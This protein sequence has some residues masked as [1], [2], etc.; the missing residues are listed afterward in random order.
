[1]DYLK[2][3]QFV[4]RLKKLYDHISAGGGI[5][6]FSC[7]RD[8]LDLMAETMNIRKIPFL[9]ISDTEGN[10][11]FLIQKDD[12]N[13]VMDVTNYV[14]SEKAQTCT[15]TS[16]DELM[17]KVL[18][19][20]SNHKGLISLTGLSAAQLYILE[21]MAVRRLGVSAIGED[22]MQDGTYRFSVHGKSAIKKDKAQVNLGLLLL[23]M[24]MM[25]EGPGKDKNNWRA[26]NGFY[27]SSNIAGILKGERT[28]P[29]YLVEGRQ[30]MKISPG[31]FECGY[32]KYQNGQFIMTPSLVYQKEIPDY[33]AQLIS[34][35]GRFAEPLCTMDI[36]EAYQSMMNVS[37]YDLTEKERDVIAS[38]KLVA[39]TVNEKVLQKVFRD[40]T[41]QLGGQY[42][43]KAAHVIGEMG[44]VMKGAINGITPPG[45]DEID[46]KS[47]NT[48][49]RTEGL[50]PEDYYGVAYSMDKL[51]I[52][53]IA[54][55]VE[56][57]DV[58]RRLAELSGDEFIYR[59]EELVI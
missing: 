46:V 17:K 15:I 43:S 6:V 14:L 7:R 28:N 49:M 54:E 39:G 12:K 10:N 20:N 19:S 44:K 4:V 38:E 55:K 58:D 45:Y 35:L 50:N 16:T 41:M 47:I 29:F 40:P 24:Q 1:M 52:V 8:A 31:E 5:S 51:E 30:Y 21:Q 48:L 22:L 11:G 36:S 57:I 25:T 27:Y 23:E 32:G 13:A 42:A 3:H 9:I 26:G 37:R 18:K 53:P 59:D 2:Q 33:E 34:N 56:L